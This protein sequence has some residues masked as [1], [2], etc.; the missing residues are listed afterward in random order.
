LKLSI[1]VWD[2]WWRRTLQLSTVNCQLFNELHMTVLIVT[3]SRDNES[4]A[5]VEKALAERGEKTFRLDTDLFP[6]NIQVEAYYTQEKERLTLTYGEAK[7]DLREVS[8]V[9]YRRNWTAAAIPATMD[10]QLRQASVTESQAT[11]MGVITSIK[12]FHLDALPN[13][14][15]ADNKQLQLQVAREIGLEIPRTLMTNSP[16]AVR[17]F[18]EECKEGLMTKMLSSFAIYEEGKE[19]VVFTN[20]VKPEDLEELDGLQFCPM[21]FQE[22]VPKAL[23]LRTIIVGKRLFTASIDS[24][25]SEKARHDWRRQGLALMNDWKPHNLPSEI[26]SKLLRLM[27][28]FGLNYGALDL[29]LTPDDRYVFLE[30]N[31]VGE[32]FWLELC[33]GLP[34][35]GAIADLLLEQKMKNQLIV[36]S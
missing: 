13:L 5:L 29:I 18:A 17:N 12:A 11:V 22:R 1:F 33:P 27:A 26:E 20:P 9:W 8:G 16:Q 36:D 14:R 31:P 15:L 25:S 34:I 30:I 6:T 3:Y 19:K 28:Y 4:I 23:E 10:V 35:S 2:S 7:I 32:F 21:T 24:Q